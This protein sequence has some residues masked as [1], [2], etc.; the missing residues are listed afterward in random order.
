MHYAFRVCEQACGRRAGL[1]AYSKNVAMY[2]RQQMF[3]GMPEMRKKHCG[4]IERLL[5]AEI[6][7]LRYTYLDWGIERLQR[8]VREG[9]SWNCY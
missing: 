9:R 4:T 5:E 6:F 7:E 3:W 2:A 1:R 8:L